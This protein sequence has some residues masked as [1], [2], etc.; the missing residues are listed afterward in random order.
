MG[1]LLKISLLLLAFLL[2]Q[3]HGETL[4]ASSEGGHGGDAKKGEK[5]GDKKDAAKAVDG[6]IAIGPVTV[7]VLSNKG[8]RFLRLAMQVECADNDAAERLLLPDAKEDLVLFLSS[9]MAEDLLG[10]PGKMILR[11]ELIDLFSKYAGAGKVKNVFFTEFVF[12]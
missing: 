8:Y 1:H 12:Q 2:T 10:N 4:Y 7:N 6:V 11:R 5:K 3:P 9:K